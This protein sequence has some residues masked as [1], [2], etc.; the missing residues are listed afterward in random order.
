MRA[1]APVRVS[2]YLI[3]LQV[4]LAKWNLMV[5]GQIAL[6]QVEAIQM[7]K[8]AL[9]EKLFFEL[10]LQGKLPEHPLEEVSKWQQL[11]LN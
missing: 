6:Q 8:E 1:P 9:Q 5:R 4:S 11:P 7:A 3:T 10:F 2:S